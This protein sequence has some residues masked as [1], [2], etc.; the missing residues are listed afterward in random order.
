MRFPL[1]GGPAQVREVCT[2][3]DATDSDRQARRARSP[4]QAVVCAE[5]GPQLYGDQYLRTIVVRKVW[6]AG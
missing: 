2:F 4:L 5:V 3:E 6:P 1:T